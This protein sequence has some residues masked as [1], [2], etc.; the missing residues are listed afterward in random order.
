MTPTQ[1]QDPQ[2]FRLGSQ[3]WLKIV[4][5][6]FAL[7]GAFWGWS[8]TLEARLARIEEKLSSVDATQIG[9]ME[10]RIENIRDQLNEEKRRVDQLMSIRNP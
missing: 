8:Q 9:R 2:T 1:R 5:L 3:E 10:E 4:G 7:C 6:V